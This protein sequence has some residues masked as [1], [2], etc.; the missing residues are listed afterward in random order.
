MKSWKNG[1]KKLLIIQN[2]TFFSGT[3]WLPKRPILGRNRNLKGSPCLLSIYSLGLLIIKD[4][5]KSYCRTK[6][7]TFMH[8]DLQCHQKKLKLMVTFKKRIHLTIYVSSSIPVQSCTP[9]RGLEQPK[10]FTNPWVKKDE[11]L[12]NQNC[13]LDLK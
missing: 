3:A 6:I 10:K 2:W 5:I 4:E 12:E 1:A 13:Y 7:A 9:H 11:C 8:T